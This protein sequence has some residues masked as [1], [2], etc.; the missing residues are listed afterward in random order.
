MAILGPLVLV[1]IWPWLWHE[2]LPRLRDSFA[3]HLHPGVQ[4]RPW[5][6][7]Q[8]PL[9]PSHPFVL[10][11]LTVP[12]ASLAAMA[13]GWLQALGRISAAVRGRDEEVRVGDEV[14][15]ALNALFPV[16]LAA[17]PTAPL[18]GGVG[19]WLPAMPF[20]ALLGARALVTAGRILAPRRP[21]AVT[22]ALAAVALAPAAWQVSRTHPLGA[23]AWNELAGGAPGAASLGMQGQLGGDAVAGALPA[24]NAHAVPG[25][26]MWFQETAGLAM[27]QYQLDG[28]LRADLAWASGPEDADLSIWQ[29]QAGSRDREYR[30]W[31]AF[32]TARP[33]AGVY[34]EEVP[35]VQVYARAGAWR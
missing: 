19:P 4:P 23:A 5:S 31:T 7:R 20:L 10:I 27:R 28:R 8:P 3:F 2:T 17:W 6:G 9:P 16:A 1:A 13:G 12:A 22:G 15:L 26:R 32:G 14:L 33:V 35:L 21:W 11:A 30:S 18:S 25:A 34:L 29:P 24:L